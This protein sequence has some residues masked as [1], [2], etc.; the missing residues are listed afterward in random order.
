MIFMRI[1]EF[2]RENQK[3][4]SSPHIVKNSHPSHSLDI[5]VDISWKKGFL[6]FDPN[7]TKRDKSVNL[8]R[9]LPRS[10]S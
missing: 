10:E 9:T 5:K 1:L 4:I 3:W 7:E 6:I 8:C 2:K